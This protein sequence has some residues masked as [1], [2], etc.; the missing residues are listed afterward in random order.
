MDWS[1][2]PD[3][4]A[5]TLLA[6][7]FAS[8][9]LRSHATASALW[10]TGWVMIALHFAAFMF[11][12]VPAIWGTLAAFVGLAALA[13]A[14]ELFRWACIPFRS[15]RSSL[16]MLCALLG[17]SALYIGILILTPAAPWALNSAAALFGI[18]PLAITLISV[19]GFTDPL[20]WTTVI[21]YGTLSIFLLAFQNRPGNG[22]D[23]ALN[24]LLFTIYFGCCINFFAMHRRATSGALV[25]IGGFFAWASVFVV[26]P[27][28]SAFL[29]SI[30]V[31]SEAWNLPKYVVAV[32]MILLVLEDQIEHNKFLAL[33]DELTGLPNRRLFQDRLS[34]ALERARRTGT[35]AALLLVDLDNFKQVNDSL[36]HHVGDMLLQQVGAIFMGRVRRSDTVARTGGDE[37]CLILEEPT[38]QADAERVANSLMHLLKKPLKLG[39]H[40]VRIGASIGIAVFPEDAADT[41]TLCIA[42]DLRMYAGKHAARGFEEEAE[43]TIVESL[44]TAEATFRESRQPRNHRSAAGSVS[45]FS[46]AS[47]ERD[48]DGQT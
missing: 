19:R 7:A 20:R 25:T 2:L 46:P 3:L 44:P 21:L 10:L 42:A 36:G 30:H 48:R 8:V 45:T 29:P 14:G 43:P 1:K 13:W 34:S 35:E 27:L 23:L 17:T 41:E 11:L 37:F 39:D 31:E 38:S 22:A 9:A 4:V 26:A 15:E 32:G 24:G 40:T 16:W 47:N 28:L 12:P 6:C 33:H 5:V 18:L